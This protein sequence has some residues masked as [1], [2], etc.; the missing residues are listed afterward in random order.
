MA[1][2]F[3]FRKSIRRDDDMIADAKAWDIPDMDA[4]AHKR[5]ENYTN[6]L[7]KKYNWVYEPPEA[8]EEAEEIKPLTIEDVEAIRQAAYEEGFAEG[9]A[10]GF[11][12]GEAEGKEQGY[13]LGLE[14]GKQQGHEEGL[15]SGTSLMEEKAEHWNQ[16]IARLDEPLKQLD[17]QVEQELIEL[18]VNLTKAVI[19]TELKTNPEIILQ[20]VKKAAEYLPFNT[21]Q[22]QLLVNPEDFDL[23]QSSYGE[24]EL[25]RRQW[26]LH[27]D[28]N[29]ARGGIEIKTELSS[30]S[31]TLEQR[32][33]EILEQFSSP[34]N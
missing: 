12:K 3:K 7:G 25:E 9:K 11:E 34:S 20:T 27:S 1:D 33:K 29:I 2:D 21:Q 16:L 13:Q 31:Y 30:V 17:N 18:V 24:K 14:Q 5:D 4:D 23:I 10:E 28:P 6:A 8:D 19:Q 15:A 32:V 26:H 22:C